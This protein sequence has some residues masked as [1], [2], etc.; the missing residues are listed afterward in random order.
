[1]VTLHVGKKKTPFTIHEDLLCSSSGYFKNLLPN[2]RKAIE[3][4]C[5]IC[6]EDLSAPTPVCYCSACGQNIHT[7]CLNNWL[8][9]EQ[10]CPL[11]RT[12]WAAPPS[13]DAPMEDRLLESIPDSIIDLYMQWLYTGTI[14]VHSIIAHADRYPLFLH[15][16]LQ[17]GEVLEDEIFLKTPP[18]EILENDT[19]TMLAISHQHITGVYC[20]PATHAKTQQF[21]VDLYTTQANPPELNLDYPQ[22]FILGVAQALLSRR[23][24]KDMDAKKVLAEY[25]PEE[26]VNVTEA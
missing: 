12:E 18:R 4:E 16:T 11:C 19:M 24:D 6:T 3:G 5:S 23:T 17:A 13:A 9:R 1:M 7:K 20:L 8:R 10:V 25:L 21:L 15:A 26:E 14:S 2:G 22:Q